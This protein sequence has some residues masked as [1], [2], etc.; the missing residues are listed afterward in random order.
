MAVSLL[1]PLSPAEMPR[2]WK[3]FPIWGN[4]PAATRTSQALHPPR[5]EDHSCHNPC[6]FNQ[7]MTLTTVV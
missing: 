2:G 7:A 3:P 5:A 4:P 6:S 1:R